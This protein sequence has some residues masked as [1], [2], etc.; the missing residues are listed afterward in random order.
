MS[1]ARVLGP[2]EVTADV[3][4]S[5]FDLPAAPEHE[6]GA[7]ALCLHGLTGTPYEVRPVAEA[8]SKRGI[9]SKGIWMAGHNGTVDD[10]AATHRDE[11][12]DVAREALEDLRRRHD[13]VFLV[14][15]SMG[16]L[17]SLRLAQTAEV[18]GLVV[19]GVPLVLAPPVPQLLPLLPLIR[20]FAKGRA[21]GVSDLADPEARARH[22]HFPMMP[23]D[24]VRELVRLQGEVIPDLGRITAPILV[25]HGE[26]DKTAAPK[27][28]TE[29]HRAVATADADKEL[30]LLARS[31]HVV[32]VDYDGPALCA[33][34]ADFLSRRAC[35]D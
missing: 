1:G 13:R 9:R 7:A 23:F 34:A 12:V 28:A 26:R 35:G 29:I 6:T 3:D 20:L 25:A 21:K 22:P 10:L 33:A 16:G 32:P 17:T 24:A 8:L 27:D 18:D 4:V 14:G 5:A 30:F 2:S 15:V 31:G 19:I 11:W